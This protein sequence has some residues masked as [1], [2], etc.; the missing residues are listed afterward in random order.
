MNFQESDIKGIK[1]LA[2][3]KGGLN[4]TRL[5]AEVTYGNGEIILLSLL[6]PN[7]S[8]QDL[9]ILQQYLLESAVAKH[10]Y[11]VVPQKEITSFEEYEQYLREIGQATE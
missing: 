1:P 3:L 5:I 8:L 9:I 7:Y 6:P 11:S 10:G 2:I 4:G